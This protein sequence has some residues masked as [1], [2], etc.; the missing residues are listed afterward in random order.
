MKSSKSLWEFKGKKRRKNKW[1]I[2]KPIN[3]FLYIYWV[4]FQILFVLLFFLL[5]FR[6]SEVVKIALFCS[7]PIIPV[8]TVQ[9]N[10][11]YIYFNYFH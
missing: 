1:K 6:L 7:T 8:D 4:L 11:Y 2:K 10:V 9:F 5:R 3:N